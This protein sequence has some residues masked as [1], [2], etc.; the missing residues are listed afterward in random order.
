MTLIVIDDGDDDAYRRQAL[1]PELSW[2]RCIGEGCALQKVHANGL[3]RDRPS[4]WAWA[5]EGKRV[6]RLRTSTLEPW[7]RPAC[8]G[9]GGGLPEGI[10]QI[11][12][13]RVVRQKDPEKK[14][15]NDG[16][17]KKTVL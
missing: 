2:C 17:K 14:T 6:G 4:P 12:Q 15:K 10:M 7:C 11:H 3:T 16:K 9:C 5:S 13:L 8:I 1:D